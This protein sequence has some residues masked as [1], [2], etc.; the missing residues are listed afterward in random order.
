MKL[1]QRKMA[2]ELQDSSYLARGEV[3][4]I[5]TKYHFSCLSTFQLSAQR[6][7]NS[8]I[9]SQEDELNQVHVFADL[10]LK[11]GKGKELVKKK[12]ETS[13]QSE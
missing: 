1:D 8:S 13:N 5:E 7:Q 2:T 12:K 10:I 4:A 3:V 9:N 6:A 11:A